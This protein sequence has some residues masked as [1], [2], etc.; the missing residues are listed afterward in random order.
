MSDRANIAVFKKVSRVCGY[1]KIDNPRGH[2]V[3]E[4]AAEVCIGEISDY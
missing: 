1:I 3:P 2:R 4:V